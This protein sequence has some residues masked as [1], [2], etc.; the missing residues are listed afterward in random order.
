MKLSI[1][2]ALVATALFAALSWWLF[3]A[4]SATVAL[5]TALIAKRRKCDVSKKE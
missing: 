5:I 4:L 3:A 1:I 2:I